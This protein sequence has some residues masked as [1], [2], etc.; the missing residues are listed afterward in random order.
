ME[1]P[2]VSEREFQQ[3]F[4]ALASLLGWTLRYHTY[5][6]RRSREG[7]PDWVLVNRRLA[8]VLFVELKTDTGKL[9]P[10]QAEWIATLK[11]CGQ[12][13]YCLRP[14]DWP[15]IQELLR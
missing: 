15:M 10:K 2:P 3:Q 14:R 1:M 12:E 11:E 13:A 8:R 6:S 9:T 4:I 7:F 5:D